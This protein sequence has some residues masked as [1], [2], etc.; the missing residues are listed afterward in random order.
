MSHECHD[1]GKLFVSDA[2][3]RILISSIVAASAL[4]WLKEFPEFAVLTSTA[5]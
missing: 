2:I 5:P 1:K 3:R 4:T